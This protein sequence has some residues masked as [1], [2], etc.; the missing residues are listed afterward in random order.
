MKQVKLMLGLLFCANAL[1]A[2]WDIDKHVQMVKD[3]EIQI[4]NET[5][6]SVKLGLSK[7]VEKEVGYIL[8]DEHAFDFTFDFKYIAA[9]KSDDG[10][11]IVISW[12]IPLNDGTYHNAGFFAY[13]YGRNKTKVYQFKTLAE[14]LNSPEMM[15]NG[16][17]G[18]KP[19]QYYRLIT[20]NDKRKTYYT[21]LGW[22]GKDDMSNLKVVDILRFSNSG[23]IYTGDKIISGKGK[24]FGHLEFEYQERSMMKLN[25]ENGAIVFDH[26]APIQ[27]QYQGMPQYYGPDGTYD[28]LIFHDGKWNLVEGIDVRNPKMK[29]IPKPNKSY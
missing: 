10:L 23:N 2:Q 11:F 12:A 18:W 6:D 22:D 27:S 25:F 24:Y 5:I 29:E 15:R 21:L 9:L 20:T 26:L 14:Q 8:M 4:K 7:K 13:S 17:S 19:V 1:L 3:L 28:G 16:K